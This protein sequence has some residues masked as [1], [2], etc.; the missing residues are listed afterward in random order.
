MY[1]IKLSCQCFRSRGFVLISDDKAHMAVIT[2]EALWER[3][4]KNLQLPEACGGF[5]PGFCDVKKIHDPAFLRRPQAASV[6]GVVMVGS[7]TILQGKDR[8]NPSI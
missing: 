4:R 5:V 8:M 7:L 6:F 2:S 1:D 3:A